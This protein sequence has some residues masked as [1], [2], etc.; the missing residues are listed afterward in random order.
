VIKCSIC[1]QEIGLGNNNAEPVNSG[2]CCDDCNWM[3][4]IPARMARLND[5]LDRAA[6]RSGGQINNPNTGSES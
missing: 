1:H 2:R 3:V 6:G 4:V 5:C